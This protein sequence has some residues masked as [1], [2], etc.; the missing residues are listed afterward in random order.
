MTGNSKVSWSGWEQFGKGKEGVRGGEE[1]E[2]SPDPALILSEE[3]TK[4]SNLHRN[5]Y[6]DFLLA[7]F[8]RAVRLVPHQSAALWHRLPSS[9]G[10][11]W[12]WPLNLQRLMW[13]TQ[14]C[15]EGSQPEGQ[16]G[17]PTEPG[18]SFIKRANG[19]FQ[20]MKVWPTGT[21]SSDAKW[22]I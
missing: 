2:C 19:N 5:I 4:L 22:S 10:A 7:E 13:K 15:K 21:W 17:F 8:K 11:T 3:W 12:T 6:S 16:A 9:Q 20:F 14:R 1:E 18:V